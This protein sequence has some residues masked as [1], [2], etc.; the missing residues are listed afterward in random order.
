MKKIALLADGWRRYVIY[1]WVE[2]IMGGSKELGLDVCLYF[3][4]TNGTWSQDSKF[5]K[6]EY[7]LN[8]L[9]DLNSFDG[10]VFDCTNTTNLDE[11]QYMVRKLQSVNVPVVSIGYKVDGFYYVG[12]DNKRLFRKVMDH[13]Y[14][15]HGCK[16]FVFAGGPPYHYENRMRFE[17]FKEALSDYGIPLTADMYMFGDFDY[18]TGVRY[19]SDWHESKKPLPDVFLCANDNIA[20]GLCATAEVLGYK[21]P[22]DFKVT[23]FDNLDKAAYFNP[24]ITTVDN[25][26]GNIGRNAL[27]IFKA[28][29]NGTG[30][31][32]DKYL[33][34]EFIPAES[35]GCP[36][37][38][39]VDYRNYIKNIIKGSV[40]R[41]QEE[42]AVM[43]LQKELEECNEYY[44]L[45]ERYSDYIQSMK[46]D[47]VYVVGVSDLAAARNNAHFR[48]HGYDIDDEV[49]LYADDKDNG[50]LEFKSVNDLMQYMQS[51]DKNTCYMYCS[52]HFRDEIVGYVILRNPE[53]LYDH[54]EQFDIQSALLKRLEN[55]FKQKVLE[56]TNNELKNLYNHDALTGLY[57]RV[58]CNE[59]VIPM[60]AELEAQN[61]GCTIVFLD[62]DDFKD[63]NDTYGHQYGDEL[64]KTVARVLDEQK[65]EG[66]MVYRF[67][68]DEFIVFIPG[69]RHD[70]AEKYIKR[71]Y[72][73]MEQHSLFISH[74]IIYTRPGSGK[75]FDDYLVSA[76]TKMYQLKQQRKQKKD[77]NFLKGVDISSVPMMVDNN[78][79]IMDREGHVCRV[80][81][82]LKLNNVNSVR[83]R[84]WNEPDKV[85]ESKGYCSLTYVLEMAH[86]IKKYKMHFLLDFHY[87]DYWADPGQQ[88]KPDAWKNL[89]F[90]EL[91][92]AVHKYTYD[93][94]YRLKIMD[95][96]DTMSRLI[97]LYNLPVYIVETAHPWRHCKGDHIS[98]ELMETAGLDA[99]SAEQKK[100]LE[101]IMQIAAEVSKD[102]GKTGVYYWEPVGVPGKGMGTWFENMGMFDEH[103]RALPGWDAIRDF[104]PKNP[105][106]K[107]LDKYIESLYEYEETP[108]VEDFM[109]LLM[110]HGNLISNPE[111]KDGFNNWQIETSLEEGQ[112]TLGKDG[113]FISSDA[114]F[115]YSISQTVDIE[116]TGE[117]IA[118]VDYRG[119]NTTGV[120][121]ELF[122]DVEDESGVH[123]YTSDIFP[124]DIRFVTHLLKPVRLQKNARVT[125]GL[126]MHTPPVFAKI[127]KISL[128]VI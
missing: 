65:P 108:E 85:P 68:G 34:S 77:S 10:V 94:L 109:K 80:F 114:N 73:I 97:K 57:N 126:R 95:L 91:K 89:S 22:Q 20:A 100:S 116:Y 96:K 15:A 38:G 40:A 27:E 99:G 75:S 33:D 53:F 51:V 2:G 46:C 112:Y 104:D 81:D 17:A 63:I 64:L 23:G 88:N 42:D 44:D 12:N 76:D 37:T 113:V 36:N 115:D 123:T 14:Y 66:S 32:S 82:F 117:Y 62:V 58:A 92:E 7:A 28:L 122:M 26:R 9:P 78:I 35:C 52:L 61:V 74:G 125:V 98:K 47:G 69:D 39:R 87:S 54:P 4:N 31:A 119:T 70:T 6:G 29:W 79:Q 120:E 45:F 13:M 106:I 49:V 124:D 30:D 11:I 55:L 111:F 8:D 41:E 50:K 83:L 19:M 25:N 102:T 107:E 103:G 43:I 48:K 86:V 24:Q 101:I 56:N 93:V 3:Y 128:V 84:I 1:S 67:G 90:D 16:S 110:I 121:V 18:Q 105:P 5:N 59:M 71:V 127:K 21:V 118:A 60:F 72:D